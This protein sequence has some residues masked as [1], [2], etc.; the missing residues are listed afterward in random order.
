MIIAMVIFRL[1]RSRPKFHIALGTATTS[2]LQ[3]KGP[4]IFF[5]GVAP[6]AHLSKPKLDERKWLHLK[7]TS[8]QIIPKDQKLYA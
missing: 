8:K 7:I 4:A 5:G 6:A 3:L 2:C 1:R